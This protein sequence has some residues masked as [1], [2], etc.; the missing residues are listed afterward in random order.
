MNREELQKA[1]ER[2]R[3][4]RRKHP[5]AEKIREN[6]LA[7]EEKRNRQRAKFLSGHNHTCIKCRGIY[8]CSNACDVAG[9]GFDNSLCDPCFEEAKFPC[10]M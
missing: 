8:S 6:A 10:S 7:D 3:R 1:V 4:W 2:V 9:E 5:G